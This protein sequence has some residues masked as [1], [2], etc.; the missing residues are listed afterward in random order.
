MNLPIQELYQFFVNVEDSMVIDY[1]KIYTF[2]SKAEI[3]KL[4]KVTEPS[5]KKDDKGNE[6]PE[7][8][9]DEYKK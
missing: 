5:V 9:T 8:L 2:L 3:E 7:Y 6:I 1:L 4:K